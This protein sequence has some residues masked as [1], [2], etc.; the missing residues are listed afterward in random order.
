[1]NNS[2]ASAAIAAL[3]IL[4]VNTS[5]SLAQVIAICG[6][7][8][9]FGYNVKGKIVDDESAGWIK[10]G[11]ANGGIQLLKDGDGFDVVYTDAVGSRSAKAVG[12]TA[13]KM[14]EDENLAMVLVAYPTATRPISVFAFRKGS[15]LDGS[16]AFVA[17]CEILHVQS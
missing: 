5:S 14:V 10:D 13:I 11:L 12:G 8:Q 1:M 15:S 16:E 4:L 6:A 7:S 17:S 3:A 9:C 2:K